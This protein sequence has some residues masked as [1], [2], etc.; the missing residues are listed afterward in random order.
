[1]DLKEFQYELPARLIA[2]HPSSERDQSRLMVIDR[3]AGSI[4]HRT[5]RELPEIL[6]ADD[7]V[8]LNNTRVFPARLAGRK[9]TGGRIEILL[10]RQIGLQRW[11]SLVRPAR[12]CPP[13]TRL[14]FEAGRFEAVVQEAGQPEKRQLEFFC[15]PG[16]FREWLY[17]LG[18]V[19]L[20]PYI[21]RPNE[22]MDRERYQ[23]VYAARM[24]SVAAPTAGLHFT[25]KLLDRLNHTEIT[26]HVGYGTFRPVQCETIEDHRM[27]PERYS[28]EKRSAE[29][30]R[31]Q[32]DSGGRIV[33]V[34]TTTTRVLEHIAREHGRIEAG[35]GS[36]DLFIYPGFHFQ[37]I[38]ALI[39]NFHLPGSTLLMLVAAFGGKELMSE[40]YEVAV[41]EEYRFYSYGD[42]M[43]IV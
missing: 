8:V 21:Q 10:L 17:R 12:R 40:A 39:T 29:W 14:V 41:R 28:V 1:V 5:F 19:P 31:R 43:L 33:A 35:D 36:T 30:I 25:R 24:G 22:E 34:G 13:G 32:K 42:A 23:T 11:E 26:L 3:A 2:Q 37:T 7:L 27:D 4:D 38:D 15:E 16:E 9:S 6:R 20:P 18:Q